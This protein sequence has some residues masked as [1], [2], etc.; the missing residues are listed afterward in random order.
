VGEALDWLSQ[1]GAA[2]MSG[3][4]ACV[5]VEVDSHRQAEIVKSRVPVHWAGYVARAMNRSPLH[6]QLG[7]TE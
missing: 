3:T 4:G 5:F 6:Q 7:L 2:R 1:F